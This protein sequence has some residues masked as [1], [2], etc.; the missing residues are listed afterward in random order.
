MR[1][2]GRS[3]PEY[4]A[5][6]ERYSLFE[7]CSQPEL[8]A[9]VTLQPVRAHGVDAAVIY[10]DIMLPVSAMGVG[11]EL[12]EGVGPV[13][14]EPI[15]TRT[16][17]ARLR[18]LDPRAD[19]AVL[20][21]RR[22]ARTLGP[23]VGAGGRR[24]RRWPVHRRRLPDRRSSQPH[25]HADKGVHV[26]GTRG[27]ARPHGAPGRGFSAYAVAQAAA[28]ADV[29]QLFDSWAG[30]LSVGDYREFVAPHSARILSTVS[31][32]TIHFATGAAHLL[33]ELGAAG[34]D[35]IGLDWRVPLDRGWETVGADRG[36]QGNLEPALLLGPFERS[37]GR[38]S[39]DCGPGRR[40]AGPH[41]QSRSRGA[42]RDRS[43]GSSQAPRARS[44][45]ERAASGGVTL[46]ARSRAHPS[47]L[48]APHAC[49]PPIRLNRE[50]ASGRPPA[51]RAES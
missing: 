28:G 18:R 11:I 15:R 46:P 43:G 49:F 29:I 25:V 31:A 21:S 32:P 10:S 36:V 16:I 12:V 7:I 51:Q 6:R 38:G 19:A 9:E 8:C 27:L 42:A 14:D 26:C 3:L 44:R 35:V 33:D 40:P 23:H 37:G 39:G 30:V 48:R 17:S 20:C 22:C 24:L 4:R 47:T 13:V 41:L 50:E 2:A 1:Q 5:V 34:G 45:A